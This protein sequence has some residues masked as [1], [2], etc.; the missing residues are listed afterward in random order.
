MV[1]PHSAYTTTTTSHTCTL[2]RPGLEG[3][4]GE[5]TGVDPNA[6][7]ETP[8]NTGS[9][10]IAAGILWA[11]WLQPLNWGGVRALSTDHI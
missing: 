7:G 4:T 9:F 11:G 1:P 10:I 5:T 3:T 6:S 8:H 2:G